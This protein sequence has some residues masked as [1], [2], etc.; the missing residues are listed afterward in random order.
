MSQL[1]LEV[2]RVSNERTQ[3]REH[4]A[5]LKLPALLKT[6]APMATPPIATHYINH[7]NETRD[8][9]LCPFDHVALL[10][11]ALR[12]SPGVDPLYTEA[13]E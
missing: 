1:K 5:V 12:G 13:L 7:R 11:P 9:I 3:E 2:G 10:G 6:L 4:S 8:V